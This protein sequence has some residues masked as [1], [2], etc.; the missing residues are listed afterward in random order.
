MKDIL[1]PAFMVFL[2]GCFF[3]L[4]IAIG[5]DWYHRHKEEDDD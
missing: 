3:G 2:S 1:I 4:F 5:A